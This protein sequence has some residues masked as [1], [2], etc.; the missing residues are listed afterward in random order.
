MQRW[1]VQGRSTGVS[2]P[3]NV[4]IYP[5]PRQS[6]KRASGTGESS[7]KPPWALAAVDLVKIPL[8][9]RITTICISVRIGEGKGSMQAVSP[10]VIEQLLKESEQHIRQRLEA[11][12]RQLAQSPHSLAEEAADIDAEERREA[13]RERCLEF[14]TR[15]GEL[16][17]ETPSTVLY[18]GFKWPYY[19]LRYYLIPRTTA[20]N[21][22]RR[23]IKR[24]QSFIQY[25][26]GQMELA[27]RDVREAYEKKDLLS[28]R[29][30]TRRYAD[31]RQRRN[32][33][34]QILTQT[35]EKVTLMDLATDHENALRTIRRTEQSQRDMRLNPE[36]AARL[37]D[38]LEDAR[39]DTHEDATEMQDEFKRAN[40][41]ELD[42]NRDVDVEDLMQELVV[43]TQ[44]EDHIISVLAEAPS[45]LPKDSLP[46]PPG[47]SLLLQRYAIELD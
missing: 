1:L 47:P 41:L 43:P 37:A 16:I 9:K 5:V 32:L 20:V 2:N 27:R 29:N 15:L 6:V 10:E 30:A 11:K 38:R 13:R 18:Y 40:E 17:R 45:P 8:R 7:V 26:D 24:Q 28:A 4:S 36:K 34:N 22:A 25:L 39:V 33:Y 3:W 31:F 46:P 14:W 42:S 21:N 44:A 19:T 35:W 23:E 12:V